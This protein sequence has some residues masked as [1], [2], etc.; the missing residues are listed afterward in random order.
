M[1]KILPFSNSQQSFEQSDEFANEIKSLFTHERQGHMERWEY[2]PSLFENDPGG[3]GAYW[4]NLVK[5]PGNYYLTEGDISCIQYAINT[6]ILQNYLP[7]VDCVI[8]LGPGSEKAILSK[9]IPFLSKCTNLRKYIAVDATL[10]QAKQSSFIVRKALSINVGVRENNFMRSPMVPVKSNQSA[11]VMWGSSLGNI[12]GGPNS[13]PQYKLI[14]TMRTISQGMNQKDILIVCFD[15]EHD[16]DKILRAYSENN[17]QSQILSV[18]YR[19][20]RDLYIGGNFNPR[21]WRHKPVWHAENRQL[22]HT[23]YPLFDQE[24]HFDNQILKIPAWTE[25]ISN[26]SYKFSSETIIS[27][28]KNAGFSAETIQNGPMALL[29]ARK[30]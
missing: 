12:E 5:D 14:E 21:V 29:L 2:G 19:S 15:T 26:N 1:R 10:E 7:M 3:G 8:E 28:A 11:I 27:A 20:K 22:A 9:T 17:L 18:I 4:A 30:Q 25:F 24:L 23:V 13:N 16:E 6:D